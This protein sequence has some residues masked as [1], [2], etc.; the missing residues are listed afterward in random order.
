MRKAPFVLAFALASAYSSILKSHSS[1][2]RMHADFR[3]PV[4]K[5]GEGSSIKE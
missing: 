4:A 2:D 3:I 1:T 5:E